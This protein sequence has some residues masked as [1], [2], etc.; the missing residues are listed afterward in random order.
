MPVCFICQKESVHEVIHARE[1]VHGTRESFTYSLC[2]AC[3]TLALIDPPAD[4]TAY[5][6]NYYSTSALDSGRLNGSSWLS[7]HFTNHLKR[8]LLRYSICGD[9]LLARYI[10]HRKTVDSLGWGPVFSELRNLGFRVSPRTRFLDVGSGSGGSLNVLAIAGFSNLTGCD[11]FI[12]KEI[13]LFPRGKI[14]KVAIDGVKGLFDIVM[15]HHSL[16]HIPD[17]ASSLKS[18]SGLL[19][20]GGVIVLRFPNIASVEFL[21]HKENWW[22]IHAPRHFFIPSHDAV[23]IMASYAGLEILKSYCDSR[24]DHYL[25][26]TEYQLDIHDRHPL[27]FRADSKGLWTELEL[28]NARQKANLFNRK[29]CGDWI[30]YIL[31]RPPTGAMAS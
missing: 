6:Q 31:H 14:L 13:N 24:F 28:E 21:K 11:P 18:A 9:G 5:Y 12:D 7:R 30:A 23:R 17:P 16:E 10:Y 22:G 29:M 2:G 1:M 3:G 19:A 8:W 27:S 20:P 25:Y 15:F 4:L 26:S